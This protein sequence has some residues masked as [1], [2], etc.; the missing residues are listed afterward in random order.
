MESLPNLDEL[1]A[2]I[3]KKNRD[4]WIKEIRIEAKK[5]NFC[6]VGIIDYHNHLWML[7]K[8][9]FTNEPNKRV[10]H[11]HDICWK[12][13]KDD[14]SMA[15]TYHSIA[16]KAFYSSFKKLIS[17]DDFEGC[18]NLI[19]RSAE[20]QQELTQKGFNVSTLDSKCDVI[21]VCLPDF[22]KFK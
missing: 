21:N 2:K 11:A 8:I 7:E 17:S 10:S 12:E 13:F 20:I 3:C 9:G 14:N 6:K 18:T 1:S 22:A 16:K 15:D 5:G 4:K 19:L